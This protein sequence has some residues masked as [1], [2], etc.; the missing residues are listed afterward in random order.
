MTKRPSA[1]WDISKE[2]NNLARNIDRYKEKRFF[3]KILNS[4]EFLWMVNKLINLNPDKKGID[5]TELCAEFD[6]YFIIISH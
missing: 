1:S 4:P 6:L 2:Y 5:L 3:P